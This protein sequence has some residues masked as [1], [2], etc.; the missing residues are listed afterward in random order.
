[1]VTSSG[2]A[3]TESGLGRPG[4]PRM[5]T[6]IGGD[7]RADVPSVGATVSAPVERYTSPRLNLAGLGV[8]RVVEPTV[9]VPVTEPATQAVTAGSLI[10]QWANFTKLDGRAPVVVD[11]LTGPVA[12]AIA[13]SRDGDGGSNT[14]ESTACH[15]FPLA[16]SY[17]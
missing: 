13:S 9:K 12:V 3:V 14:C 17:H 5:L 2:T 15:L 6:G 4:N 11:A 10:G 7:T 8:V 1:M 16:R